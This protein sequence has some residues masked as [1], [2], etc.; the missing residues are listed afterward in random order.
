MLALSLA[1]LLAAPALADAQARVAVPR[2]Q[3][4]GSTVIVGA[5]YYNPYYFYRPY[6][7]GGY[8]SPWYYPFS[9]SLWYG[10]G[11]GMLRLPVLRGLSVRA[12]RITAATTAA[13][14]LRIQVP[15][16]DAEVYIDGYYAGRVDN[17]DGTFQRLHHRAGRAR[18]R[19]IPAGP[20]EFH[21][22]DLHA[23]RLDVSCAAHDGAARPRRDPSPHGPWRRRGPNDVQTNRLRGLIV[24]LPVN[25]NGL[26]RRANEMET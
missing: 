24:Q 8:Y 19:V 14:S 22:E 23:A 13:S 4:G 5:R 6:Y 12:I 21:A 7:Y 10:A 3:S 1:A 15:Q 25:L 18:P 20:P 2:S 26:Q 16:R 17:F 11:Y 9:F